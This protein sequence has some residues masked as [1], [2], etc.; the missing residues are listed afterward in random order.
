MV[1]AL[2]PPGLPIGQVSNADQNTLLNNQQVSV[3]PEA[4]IRHLSGVQILTRPHAGTA[5]AQVP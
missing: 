5:R 2:Y 3:Q 4:S 1:R